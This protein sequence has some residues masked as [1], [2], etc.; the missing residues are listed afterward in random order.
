MI[1]ER[2]ML[3]GKYND[4]N[5]AVRTRLFRSQIIMTALFVSIFLSLPIF[6]QAQAFDTLVSPLERWEGCQKRNDPFN[7]LT[8]RKTEIGTKF[9][10]KVE[11]VKNRDLGSVLD[12]YSNNVHPIRRD[13]F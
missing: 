7:D 4:R 3:R 13:T 5:K 6:A 12:T 1:M 9:R 2:T 11:S 10:A 8:W